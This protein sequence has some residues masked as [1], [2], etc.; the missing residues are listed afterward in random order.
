MKIEE[1]LLNRVETSRTK[2]KMA[3]KTK[4]KSLGPL[5]QLIPA[6]LKITRL[7][8]PEKQLKLN[9]PAF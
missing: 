5:V 1:K 4:N 6:N 8:L 7:P 2:Q 9:Q 3:P